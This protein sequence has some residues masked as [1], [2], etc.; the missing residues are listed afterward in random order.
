M[1]CPDCGATTRVLETREMDGDHVR[2]RRACSVCAR[3]FTTAEAIIDDYA[4]SNVVIVQRKA[5]E[6]L[7]RDTTALIK[8]WLEAANKRPKLDG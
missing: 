5:L 1:T 3:R 6:A 4:S 7:L 2:R 8:P